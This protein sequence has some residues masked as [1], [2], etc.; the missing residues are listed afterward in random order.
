V[1]C[2]GQALR[3]RN[4]GRGMLSYAVPNGARDLVLASPAFIPAA[5]IG[6]SLDIRTLGVRLLQVRIDGN[7]LDMDAPVFGAG[8]YPT[9]ESTEGPCRWTNGRATLT[10]PA[11]TRRITLTVADRAAPRVDC[12]AS[13]SVGQSPGRLVLMRN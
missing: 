9:E 11:N 1:L 10:L 12:T 13:R 4:L 5:H 6:D 8:F 2:N 7:T 3:S